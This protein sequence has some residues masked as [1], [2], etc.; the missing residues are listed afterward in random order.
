MRT[1]GRNMKKELILASGSPRRH[2]ILTLAG[3]PHRVLVPP[4]GSADES[5][6]RETP[7][8]PGAYVRALARRKNRAASEAFCGREELRSA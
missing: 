1:E 6:V 7:D 5:S 2:E 4:A 8:D 3:I